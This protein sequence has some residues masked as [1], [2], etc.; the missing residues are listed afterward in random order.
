M[1]SLLLVDIGRRHQWEIR[2]DSYFST[3]WSSLV[4]GSGLAPQYSPLPICM[5]FFLSVSFLGAQTHYSQPCHMDNCHVTHTWREVCSS[6]I[7]LCPHSISCCVISGKESLFNFDTQKSPFVC[8]HFSSLKSIL[9]QVYCSLST[10]G[11]LN[12][13]NYTDFKSFWWFKM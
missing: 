10:T 6:R 1:V 3:G 8:F 11:I 9:A 2:K 5:F 7:L 13:S 4:R 12:H